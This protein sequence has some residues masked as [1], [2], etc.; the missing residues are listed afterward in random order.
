MGLAES[1]STAFG[2]YLKA[3]RERRGLSLDDVHSLSQTF[4]DKIQKA[5]LSKCE[6]G[7]SRLAVS[8]LIPLSRIYEVP[9]DAIAERSLPAAVTGLDRPRSVTSGIS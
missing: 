5:H 8:K 3:L 7:R 9:S 2:R 4:P 6:N 1:C